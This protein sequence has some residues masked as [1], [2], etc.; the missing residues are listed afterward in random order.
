VACQPFVVLFCVHT[1]PKHRH[2]GLEIFSLQKLAR[3]STFAISFHFI[4]MLIR[5]IVAINLFFL[6]AL[7]PTSVLA[8]GLAAVEGNLFS[9]CRGGSSAKERCGFLKTK[10]VV[11]KGTPGTKECQQKC[12]LFPFLS[13]SYDCGACGPIQAPPAAPVP[14]PAPKAPVVADPAPKAP[15][16]V[17]PNTAPSKPLVGLDVAACDPATSILAFTGHNEAHS[18]NRASVNVTWNPAFAYDI[19]TDKLIW[20][21]DFTYTLLVTPGE[22]NFSNVNRTATELIRFA[23]QADNNIEVYNTPNTSWVQNGLTPGATYSILVLAQ[24]Q[25]GHVSYNREPAVVEVST[26][27]PKLNADFKRMIVNPEPTNDTFTILD[28]KDEQVVV[29]SG[30][31]PNEVTSLV[32]Q[33]HMY[34]FDSD[35][36]ATLA[37][38]LS[39]VPSGAGTIA[40]KYKASD[41]GDVFDELDI[42]VDVVNREQDDNANQFDAPLDPQEE[43]QLDLE[44]AHLHPSN[45]KHLCMMAYPGREPFDC[46]AASNDPRARRLFFGAL[47]K[48]VV[49]A[50]KKVAKA[51]VK[52]VV[53]TVKKVVKAID[54]AIP[55]LDKTVTLFNIDDGGTVTCTSVSQFGQ[56][57]IEAGIGFDALARARIKIKLSL[58]TL[59]KRASI[60]LTGGFGIT[61]YVFLA[62]REEFKFQPDPLS[63]F[64]ISQH[65]V[66]PVGPVPVWIT[67]RQS[68]SGFLGAVAVVETQGLVTTLYG[69]DYKFHFSF[70]RDRSKPFQTSSKLTKRKSPEDEPAF[71]L[72]ISAEAEV[73]ITLAWDTLVFSL[74][75]ASIVA[76]LGLR[77]ELAVSTNVEGTSIRINFVTCNLL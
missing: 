43:A 23:E 22:F 30:L 63:L 65:Y 51:V 9:R 70:D 56:A 50:V 47:I 71:D 15:V 36:N 41:L 10:W 72:R 1:N 46:F 11:H 24:T 26:T 19:L 53:D 68:L 21:G 54:N 2:L 66:I 38:C 48:A 49:K 12:V 7:V 33:D 76:D 37:R 75:Q 62:G 42:S 69:Y 35:G 3:Y 25:R 18:K 17:A 45:K 57:K 16:A 5:S 32:P 4:A 13:S 29:F 55:E 8:D 60:D 40:W 39:I 59:V 74:L 52:A 58:L 61:T 6:V 14:A 27:D 77:S 73:G 34:F 44:I 64:K 31:L 67:N 28:K 20:C